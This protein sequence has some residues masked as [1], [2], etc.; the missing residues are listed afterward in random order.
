MY[1]RA[2]PLVRTPLSVPSQVAVFAKN[3]DVS[4]ELLQFRTYPEL[5]ESLL[6]LRVVQCEVATCTKVSRRGACGSSRNEGWRDH[7]GSSLVLLEVL[8]V[9]SGRSISRVYG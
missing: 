2:Y 1:L 5:S 6:E 7:C 4:R 8:V 9:I 3:Y